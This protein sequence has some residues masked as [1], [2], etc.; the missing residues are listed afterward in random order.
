VHPGETPSSYVFKGFLDFITRADDPRAA[1]LRD[2]F[3]FKLIPLLNPDGVKRGHYRTDQ[4]GVNLN[5]VY[6]DP[7]LELHPTIFAAKSLIAYHY[8]GATSLSEA[9]DDGQVLTS[10][11]S[12]SC[13][14]RGVHVSNE[15]SSGSQDNV[16]LQENST[17]AVKVSCETK[18]E[19]RLENQDAS[20][21]ILLKVDNKTEQNCSHVE[22]TNDNSNQA[23]CKTSSASELLTIS[24]SKGHGCIVKRTESSESSDSACD[25]AQN[26]DC[27][28]DK[29]PINVNHSGSNH[30]T[31]SEGDSL[32]DN[33][34]NLCRS[35][36]SKNNE[37]IE[38][39]CDRCS[40]GECTTMENVAE[41]GNGQILSAQT[42]T[43]DSN[44]NKNLSSMAGDSYVTEGSSK[45]SSDAGVSS[46]S[47]QASRDDP[48][49]TAV[50]STCNS[51]PAE[52]FREQTGSSQSPD[53]SCSATQS[54]NESD[55]IPC[56]DRVSQPGNDIDSG[57]SMPLNYIQT[58]EIT[59]TVDNVKSVAPSAAQGSGLEAI[60]TAQKGA[61]SHT[62]VQ[63]QNSENKQLDIS[64]SKVNESK[65]DA[66]DTKLAF[67][68]DLHGHASKRG[69]FMYG[70]YF[71]DEESYAQ[72][73]LFPKLISMN[74]S[75]FDF[76][77]CNF[78]EKN[79]YSRDRRDGMSKEGSGRVAVYKMTGLPYW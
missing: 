40:S 36:Q 5:R 47:H 60:N 34:S 19:H 64:A 26:G 11:Q 69:C 56:T 55:F 44:L 29:N 10:V 16:C 12:P 28:S 53:T 45:D 22:L 18:D 46:Q 31:L 20:G 37:Q 27:I 17:V 42:T 78:T 71:E 73:M 57:E 9:A 77:A 79:M 75:H 62:M 58:K 32:V 63:A 61:N 66:T 70:N 74:S 23:L 33:S 72:C 35:S 51:E 43:H 52:N 8:N 39:G 30:S 48:S 67:Y 68:V 65:L 21:Q 38:S 6:L 41:R 3:V 1:A 49:N 7:S 24:D 13:E 15:A 14:V 2:R 59:V 25:N 4:R 76:T 54:T 50:S